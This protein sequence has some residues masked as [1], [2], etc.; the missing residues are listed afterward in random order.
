MPQAPFL[1]GFPLF[2]ALKSVS[3]IKNQKLRISDIWALWEY[4]IMKQ[5]NMKAATRHF[6]QTLL[7]QAQYF[8]ETAVH[9]PIKSQPLLYYY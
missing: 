2:T 3:S 9:A 4:I 5:A 8:Y 1:Y 7:E 6:L